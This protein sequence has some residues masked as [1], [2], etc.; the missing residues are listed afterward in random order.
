[1]ALGA[2]GNR[3]SAGSVES[4]T[5]RVAAWAN[6][7][8]VP[9]LLVALDGNEP[10]GSASLIAHDLPDREELW[11]LW[12]WLSGV[13]VVPDHRGRG[14]ARALVGAVE[15]AARHLGATRLYLYTQTAGGLY[16]RLGWERIGDVTVDGR[17]ADLMTK[18][19]GSSEEARAEEVAWL[20]ALRP[21][22]IRAV[23]AGAAAWTTVDLVDCGSGRESNAIRAVLESL[24]V[25]VNF[26]GVGQAR[27]LASVLD[28]T[29]GGSPWIVLCCHGDEGGIVLPGLAPQVE[30][31]QPWHGKVGAHELT[32]RVRLPGRHV[33]CTGCDTGTAELAEAFFGGGCAAY[34]APTGA[35]FGYAGVI[36]VTLVFYELTHDR[37]LDE[38][39]SKLAAIDDELAMWRLFS[40]PGT[41]APPRPAPAPSAEATA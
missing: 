10:I 8:A 29:E 3:R 15:Q 5:A 38:A 31:F 37:G 4:W 22:R 11:D 36:A 6:R 33:I 13:Y 2:V 26:F 17:A 20:A 9:S 39:V 1:M 18:L 30:R 12:P 24:G 19:L 40:P 34:L 14:V 16:E 32:N 21:S 41:L 23:Q 25:R 7:A 28:G 27:H 35:P